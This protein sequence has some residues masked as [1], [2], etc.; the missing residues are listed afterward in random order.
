M[1]ITQIKGLFFL[2]KPGLNTYM[3]HIFNLFLSVCIHVCVCVCVMD[4][5]NQV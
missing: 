4:A 5:H 3:L 2:I 1:S